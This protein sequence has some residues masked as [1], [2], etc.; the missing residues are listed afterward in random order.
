MKVPACSAAAMRN[1]PAG[2]VTS[3][4]SSTN[5]T[6]ASA[7]ARGTM[8]WCDV[9]TGSAIGAAPVLDVHQEFVPEHP[10]GRGDRRRD[11]RSQDADGRLLGRPRHPGGEVVTD[12]HEQV[13]VGLAP[14]AVLDAPQD[15]LQ[16]PTALATRR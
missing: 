2:T 8:P 13:D 7:S 9:T 12:V 4:P 16:P 1:W 6:D 3:R 14:V 10:D 15:L 11:G 5:V